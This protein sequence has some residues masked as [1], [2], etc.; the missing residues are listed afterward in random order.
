MITGK[1]LREY[2]DN[3]SDKTKEVLKISDNTKV[4]KISEHFSFFRYRKISNSL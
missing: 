3:N 2:R 4:L 1:E